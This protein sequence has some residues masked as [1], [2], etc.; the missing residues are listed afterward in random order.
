MTN[1]LEE[2]LFSCL[3]IGNQQCVTTLK[4][5]CLMMNEAVQLINI[6]MSILGRVVYCLNV[7]NNRLVCILIT[8]IL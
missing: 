4:T 5:Y 8:C 2:M 6:C 1:D 7:V 3:I